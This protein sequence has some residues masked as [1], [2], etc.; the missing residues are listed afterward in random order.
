MGV[1]SDREGLG[2][3]WEGCVGSAQLVVIRRTCRRVSPRFGRV[4]LL[5]V[6]GKMWA[7][8]GKVRFEEEV[9]GGGEILAGS[10]GVGEP[11]PPGPVLSQRNQALGALK[12]LVQV[13]WP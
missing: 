1:T 8:V 3:P 5:R 9:Q 7:G 2:R 13:L 4:G 6:G 10:G 12:A 11:L